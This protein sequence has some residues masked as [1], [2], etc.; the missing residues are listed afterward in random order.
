MVGGGRGWWLAVREEE[1]REGTGEREGEEE[2]EERER[3]RVRAP[4][5][6][7]IVG[8]FLSLMGWASR[9]DLGYIFLLGFFSDFEFN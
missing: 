8:F 5:F 3:F 7:Y 9:L 6:A 1:E 2:R 4:I